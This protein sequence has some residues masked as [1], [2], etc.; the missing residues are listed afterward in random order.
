M[1]TVCV[2]WQPKLLSDIGTEEDYTDVENGLID[3]VAREEN[4]ISTRSH[5][6][7]DEAERTAQGQLIRQRAAGMG[8][9]VAPISSDGQ[10]TVPLVVSPKTPRRPFTPSS[11]A[12]NSSRATISEYLLSASESKKEELQIK[13]EE[14][15]L[16][17]RH[18]R[19]ELTRLKAQDSTERE[20]KLKSLQIQQQQA[21]NERA[22]I[23]LQA[24]QLPEEQRNLVLS[25]LGII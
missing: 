1:I 4:E 17:K 3:L 15:Q 12:S 25:A 22:R 2:L 7:A 21:Q 20:F 5:N 14:L 6:T 18:Q 11:S 9:L 19:A 13:Q 8:P 23:V 16:K 24:Q 10:A